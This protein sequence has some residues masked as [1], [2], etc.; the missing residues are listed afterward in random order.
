MGENSEHPKRPKKG[1]GYILYSSTRVT[2]LSKIYYEGLYYLSLVH[3]LS[4]CRGVQGA[5]AVDSP[6]YHRCSICAVNVL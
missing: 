1:R 5:R 4:L 2:V 6:F 3:V